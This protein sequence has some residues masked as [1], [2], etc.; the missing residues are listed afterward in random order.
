MGNTSNYEGEILTEEI[1]HLDSIKS[2]YNH[3]TVHDSHLSNQKKNIVFS[4]I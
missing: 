3:T 1:T 2:S 4:V